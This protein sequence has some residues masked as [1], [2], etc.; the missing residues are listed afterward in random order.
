MPQHHT[1][2]EDGGADAATA[3][4]S[5]AVLFYLSDVEEEPQISPY[6][7]DSDEEMNVEALSS[8]AV[9][10]LSLSLSLS[11]YAVPDSE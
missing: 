2:H 1:W 3:C 4:R 5:I 9:E 6:S 11:L 10:T 7:V 8:G